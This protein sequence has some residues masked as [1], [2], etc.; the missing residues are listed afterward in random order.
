MANIT[1]Q[2]FI[3]GKDP[4]MSIEEE[5]GW[6]PGPVCTF[7]SVRSRAG[8]PARSLSLHVLSYPGFSVVDAS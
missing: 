7:A 2:L 6:A 5:A 8:R 4:Q 1:L 3:P